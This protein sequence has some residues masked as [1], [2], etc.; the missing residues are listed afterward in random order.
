M[1]RIELECITFG[2]VQ[3]RLHR[4]EVCSMHEHYYN[5]VSPISTIWNTM[6]AES[7]AG[8]IDVQLCLGY[9]A[10]LARMDD[11]LE[12]AFLYQNPTLSLNF[13]KLVSI[14]FIVFKNQILFRLLTTNHVHGTWFNIALQSKW[15][16]NTFLQ[17]FCEYFEIFV[18]SWIK[19]FHYIVVKWCIQIFP[20]EAPIVSLKIWKKIINSSFFQTYFEP[21][22]LCTFQC[23]QSQTD[24]FANK[25]VWVAL[26]Q[27]GCCIQNHFKV[28]R[29]IDIY[30]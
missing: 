9:C 30:K 27:A 25:I 20:M 11:C 12:L 23:D 14:H 4:Q 26:V 22:D 29:I 16:T 18:E 2:Q 21:I 13:S 17:P 3:N 7:M 15:L 6:L 1:E 28:F 19:W 5:M 10:H 8:K 24:A